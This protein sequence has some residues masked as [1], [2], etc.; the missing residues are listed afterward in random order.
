MILV[1]G[2]GLGTSWRTDPATGLTGI[3]LTQR[4]MTRPKPTTLATD[5]WPLGQEA[6]A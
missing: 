1:E 2:G 6:P 5:F 3:L 4:L